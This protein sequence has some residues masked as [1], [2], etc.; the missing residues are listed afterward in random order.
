[1]QKLK[2][3]ILAIVISLLMIV[4]I[5][6]ATTTLIQDAHAAITFPTFGYINVAPNP[7]GINQAVTVDFWLA[8]PLQDSELAV[9]MTVYVT[10]PDGTHT[11]LGPFT[12]DITGG[13]T[14]IYTPTET[15][16]YSFYMTYGGQTLKNGVYV[17]DIESPC[18]S[19][20]VTL[21]VQS[22]PVSSVPFSPLPSQYWQTPVN[23]ENV[24]NWA[25]IIGPWLG[26]AAVFSA[27]TGQYND[28]GDY[29][30]Y[31]TCPT[32]AHILW[33]K[34]WIIGGVAGGDAGNTETSD[35]WTT[36]QYEPRW[37]PVVIDGI[38]Y[39]T[40]FTTDTTYS[41]GIVATN[42]Y[43]GQTLWVI[44]TTNPLVM[45]MQVAY[46]TPNQYGVC[47]PYLVTTGTL[48]AG[49]TGGTAYHNSGTEFNLY[50]A[51]TG[52]YVCSITNG[53]K[54]GFMTVDSLGDPVM[55]YV[56][57][58]SGTELVH[59]N[60]VTNVVQTNT[61]PT[62]NCWNMTQCLGEN[63]LDFITGAISEWNLAE[64]AQFLFNNG[65]MWSAQTIP[66]RKSVV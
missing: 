64:N 26:L 27:Q 61:G 33:T 55:Y 50:D 29:N 30:P 58:T 19:P 63:D 44:N 36:S 35:Y 47:G 24:Q 3:K 57:N 4:S 60:A 38:E 59:P 21:T 43:N 48:P 12:S 7:V 45:G 28:S 42:L 5:G 17:G 54:S 8:V 52:K 2:N 14:T 9:G 10:L 11:T 23:A 37:A 39:S 62:L 66:D 53:T 15:G 18:T 31:T 1:M 40:W 49:D 16:T 32:T 6:G 20:T 41:N 25:P 22:T 34:Q 51:L 65:L 56:N 13:T 46:E